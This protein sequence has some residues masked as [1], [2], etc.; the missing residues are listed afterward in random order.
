MDDSAHNSISPLLA[1]NEYM[2]QRELLQLHLTPTPPR[3]ASRILHLVVAIYLLLHTRKSP[4][5]VARSE[6]PCMATMN[7]SETDL[8]LDASNIL[9]LLKSSAPRINMQYQVEL[10]FADVVSTETGD[11]ALPNTNTTPAPAIKSRPPTVLKPC[12][13]GRQEEEQKEGWN[14]DARCHAG[15]IPAMTG[16]HAERDAKNARMDQELGT[17]TK[18]VASPDM[19]LTYCM[20]LVPGGVPLAKWPIPDIAKELKIMEDLRLFST[21]F[22]PNTKGIIHPYLKF[23][24]VDIPMDDFDKFVYETFPKWAKKDR[25][26]YNFASSV[27]LSKLPQIN[28]AGLHVVSLTFCP[29]AYNNNLARLCTS[30]GRKPK[31][32]PEQCANACCHGKWTPELWQSVLA[33]Y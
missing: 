24:S 2:K 3:F 26:F 8:M 21:R 23:S 28:E 32:T 22:S 4:P 13:R 33:G 12:K 16:R 27:G 31:I 9:L 6:N 29:C 18:K 1:R 11:A 14:I 5:R 19:L 25:A 17:I 15:G 30:H 7:T 10:P 20:D